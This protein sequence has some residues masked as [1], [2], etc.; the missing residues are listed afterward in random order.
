MRMSR[1]VVLTASIAALV[2][3]FWG[4]EVGAPRLDDAREHWSARD[5][6]R[7][8]DADARQHVFTEAVWARLA[9]A[10]EENDR[11]AVVADA[12]E[13][14]EIRNYAGYR[15][16][17]AIQV[18]DPEDANVVVYYKGTPELPDCEPLTRDVCVVRRE[19]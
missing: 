2:S 5:P 13:Q 6:S 16:L 15:L 14:H 12:V 17:P 11:Y 10:V 9:R 3:A 8:D 18:Q 1:A 4:L 19:T 7:R